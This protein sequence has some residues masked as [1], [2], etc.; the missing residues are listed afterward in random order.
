M[1]SCKI[2]KITCL[3]TG[4]NYIGS[5]TKDDINFRVSQH[6]NTYSSYLNNKSSYCTSFEVIRH[7]NITVDLLEE[8]TCD[9]KEDMQIRERYHIQNNQCVNKNIPNRTIKQYY[10]DKIEKYKNHYQKIKEN[11]YYKKRYKCFCGG[12]FSINNMRQHCKTQKHNLNI[13]VVFDTSLE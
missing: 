10:M 4:L 6:I 8:F 12:S 7:G 3:E 1:K 11:D 2:Y 13:P 5:T 9:N